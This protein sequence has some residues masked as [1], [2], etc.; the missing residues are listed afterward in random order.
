MSDLTQQAKLRVMNQIDASNSE[1][2]EFLS[3]YVQFRSINPDMLT[4]RADTEMRQCHE[5]L[6][7]ELMRWGSFDEVKLAAVDPEEPNVVARRRGQGK[8]PGQALLFTGHTDVVP[9]TAEQAANWT[10]GTPFGGEVIDGKLWGRGA[11]DMKGGNASFLWA[12]KSLADA[13]VQLNADVLAGCVAGEET[14]HHTIGVDVLDQAGY[15]APFAVLTEPTALEICAATIGE[16]YFLIRV[17]GKSASLASRHLYVNP[18][19]YGVPMAGVNAIDK[20]WKIQQ[21]LMHLD[22]EWTLWQ[23]HPL[24]APGNMNMNFS[25]IH[26]GETYSAMAESCELT[27]SVLF[28]PSLRFDEVVAEFRKAIDGV[29][30][31]DYWL[32][33]HPPEITV[34]YILDNKEPINLSPEHPGSQALINAYRQVFG[35]EPVLTCE[36]GTTD[37]NY[38][39]ARGQDIITFGPGYGS[40]GVHG[41]NEY[42]VVENLVKAAKVYAL[43][44]IEWC[45]VASVN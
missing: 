5:W 16:F 15:T 36:T 37:G 8:G 17:Q 32:R 34:P 3:R 1:L 4:N 26:G 42:I 12:I 14:G 39:S 11:S 2:T 24:M 28:N 38:V 6:R 7:D 21:A 41:P 18:Q 22:R 35:K 43:M 27:G 40:A 13:G 29:V 30:Q 20:M 9:V 23:R 19:P 31:V 45:G 10:T 33:E 25:R 44:A